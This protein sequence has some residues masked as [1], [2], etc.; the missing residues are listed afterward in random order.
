MK[1]WLTLALL[2]VSLPSLAHDMPAWEYI[3]SVTQ[4]NAKGEF[5]D[6]VNVVFLPGWQKSSHLYHT[7]ALD[8]YFDLRPVLN[9]KGDEEDLEMAITLRRAGATKPITVS[10]G[11]KFSE[12]S[13]ENYELNLSARCFHRSMRGQ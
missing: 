13:V 11:P 3:C 1:L 5:K 8:L 6:V 7:D 4:P 2:L 10:T 12:I 9:F